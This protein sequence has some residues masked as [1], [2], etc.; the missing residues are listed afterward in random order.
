MNPPSIFLDNKYYNSCPFIIFL[1]TQFTC[2]SLRQA[3]HPERGRAALEVSPDSFHSQG[4]GRVSSIFHVASLCFRSPSGLSPCWSHFTRWH[5]YMEPRKHDLPLPLGAHFVPRSQVPFPHREGNCSTLPVQPFPSATVS[6]GGFAC[7]YPL[8]P[9]P[10]PSRVR[11][12]NQGLFVL[13]LKKVTASSTSL[14]YRGIGFPVTQKVLC[15]CTKLFLCFM[16][17]GCVS[18][19]LETYK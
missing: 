12:L 3:Q 1:Q 6:H 10:G 2:F 7:G 8:A 15:M 4:V 19:A 9:V 18:L 16:T 17:Y 5:S 13:H 14:R 11:I